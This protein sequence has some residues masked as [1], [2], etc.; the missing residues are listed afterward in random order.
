[1]HQNPK[2]HIIFGFFI[3]N[4]AFIIIIVGHQLWYVSEP[5]ALPQS[6][7]AVLGNTTVTSPL[8]SYTTPTT[9]TVTPSATLT[10]MPTPTIVQHSLVVVNA[11]KDI[12]EG[13]NA[14]FTWQVNGFPKII[15]TTTIYYGTTSQSVPNIITAAPKDTP[16]TES[17]KDFMQGEYATPLQFIAGTHIATPGT[18]YFRA[19]ALIDGVHY[20]SPE[21]A[22]VVKALPHYDLKIVDPPKEI[23]IGK[24]IAFTWD[25]YG[26]SGT[27]GFTAIV[28]GKTSKSEALNWSIDIPKTPY[29]IL[30]PDFTQGSFNVPLRFI[31]NKVL[32]EPGTYYYRAILFINGR[33]FWSDEHSVT[34]Q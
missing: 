14:S 10:P 33:N 9:P 21:Q 4:T 28:G 30:V 3:L 17:I 23:G 5:V 31:G 1:M 12:T 18:Y 22:F 25:V 29:S 32:T 2:A 20:W 24:N 27:S 7:Q 15:H 13:D 34:V 8:S 6:I 26:P 16:Y 11:P 19:Y